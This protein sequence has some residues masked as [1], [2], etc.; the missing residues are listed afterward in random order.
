MDRMINGVVYVVGPSID[1]SY[2]NSIPIEKM[3]NPTLS[4]LNSFIYDRY[5][6]YH[7]SQCTPC[8]VIID[9]ID[10]F[11]NW[12]WRKLMITVIPRAKVMNM[13]F[14]LSGATIPEIDISKYIDLFIKT[15]YTN[16]YQRLMMWDE[17]TSVY[18]V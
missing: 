8:A 15:K 16:P 2:I 11:N 10:V 9:A 5:N 6:N 18:Q 14:V 17:F 3:V 7:E 12:E 1:K 13:L 4:D